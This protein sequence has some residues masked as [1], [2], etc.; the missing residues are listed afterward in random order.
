MGLKTAPAF[1]LSNRQAIILLVLSHTL[2]VYTKLSIVWN[3]VTGVQD[4]TEN[5][6]VYCKNVYYSYLLSIAWLYH[7]AKLM[8]HP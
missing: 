8:E 6:I 2:C 4:F 7:K 1:G 3:K 5:Q